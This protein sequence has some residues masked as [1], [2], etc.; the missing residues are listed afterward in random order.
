MQN[1]VSIVDEPDDVLKLRIKFNP[2]DLQFAFLEFKQW[3][4]QKRE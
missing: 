3:L 2:K 4:R 1:H